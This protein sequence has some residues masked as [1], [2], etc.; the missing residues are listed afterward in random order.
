MQ[1]THRLIQLRSKMYGCM[2]LRICRYCIGIT[3]SFSRSAIKRNKGNYGYGIKF[4]NIIPSSF[5]VKSC[6]N[7]NRTMVLV[8]HRYYCLS[9]ISY[10]RFQIWCTPV[11]LLSGFVIGCFLPIHL[12]STGLCSGFATAFNIS[13]F[14][15]QLNQVKII[16]AMT[17]TNPGQYKYISQTN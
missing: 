11:A 6:E 13:R 15:S 7:T 4:H 3:W 17:R 5:V 10:V 9:E 12:F 14:I 2:I 8:C 1:S 16:S